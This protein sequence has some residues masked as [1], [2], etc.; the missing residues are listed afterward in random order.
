MTITILDEELDRRIQ[1]VAAAEKRSADQI[2]TDLVRKNLTDKPAR[3]AKPIDW[4]AI[5]VIQERI[6]AL[7][8]LD[9]R[10]YDE[11]LYDEDGLPH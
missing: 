5:R 9:P 7:P 1:E 11:I 8:V 6:A 2:V 10:P 3:M 4:A